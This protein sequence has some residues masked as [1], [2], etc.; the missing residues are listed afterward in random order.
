MVVVA[1]VARKKYVK[2]NIDEYF[3]DRTKNQN[4]SV[5]V[6]PNAA[7]PWCRGTEALRN[8]QTFLKLIVGEVKSRSL[9]TILSHITTDA[10]TSVQVFKNRYYSTK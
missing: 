7:G 2:N 8:E 1:V 3:L 10:T 4:M 9:Y 5:Y 6:D